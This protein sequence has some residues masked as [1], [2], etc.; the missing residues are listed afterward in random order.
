MEPTFQLTPESAR[1]LALR[2]FTREQFQA[3]PKG[4]IVAALSWLDA[5]AGESAPTETLKSA[6]VNPLIAHLDAL[7]KAKGLEVVAEGIKVSPST[8][9]SWLH[10]VRP[11][12]VNCKR[13][14]QF[15]SE[16]P[17]PDAVEPPKP[18]RLFWQQQQ[19]PQ[20]AENNDE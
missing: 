15:L 17:P 13:I 10:G 8:L 2:L 4:C 18:C 20:P 9:R 12:E 19:E 14:E 16:T 6:T 5:A 3:D 11:T 7:V 1:A